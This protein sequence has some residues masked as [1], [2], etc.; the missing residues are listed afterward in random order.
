M[1]GKLVQ[2]V[3]Y[4]TE[5]HCTQIRKSNPVLPYIVHPIDV[6]NLLLKAGVKDEE[7]LAAAVLHDTV[8]DTSV[9][10]A[11]LKTEFGS[12]IAQLVMHCTDDKSLDKV[13]RKRLQIEHATSIPYEAALIKVAD[14]VSNLQY[15]AQSRP[16]NWTAD[17]IRGYIYWSYAVTERIRTRFREDPVMTLLYEGL[18]SIYA[19]VEPAQ[20]ETELEQYYMRLR[21]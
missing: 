7:V 16:E 9:T 3:R 15:L 12:A 6:M 19:G 8:E 10:E 11:D 18:G 4:A 1:S 20:L 14:K 5:A 17:V 13:T 21:A 2:A